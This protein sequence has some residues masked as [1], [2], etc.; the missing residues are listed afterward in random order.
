MPSEAAA[1]VAA[2]HVRQQQTAAM[3]HQ[4]SNLLNSKAAAMKLQVTQC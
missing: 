3:Q 1:A 2:S 4:H